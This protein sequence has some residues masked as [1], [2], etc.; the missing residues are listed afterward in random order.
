MCRLPRPAEATI[1]TLV[2]HK[3][4]AFKTYRGPNTASESESHGT[5]AETTLLLGYKVSQ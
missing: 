1:L 4:H 3:K 2:E 5:V